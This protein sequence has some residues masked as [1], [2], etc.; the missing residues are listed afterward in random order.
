SVAIGA[1]FARAY[2]E[3]AEHKTMLQDQSYGFNKRRLRRHAA[4]AEAL[5]VGQNVPFPQH[6][7]KRSEEAWPLTQMGEDALVPASYIF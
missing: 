1:S 5:T 2:L 3:S 4:D 7:A 6:R